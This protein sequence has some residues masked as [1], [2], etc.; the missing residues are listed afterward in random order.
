MTPDADPTQATLH[1]AS[2]TRLPDTTVAEHWRFTADELLGWLERKP[3]Q[4]W[5][6]THDTP[7]W[8]PVLY[9]PPERLRENIK[10]VYALVLD[11]DKGNPDFDTVVDLWRPFAGLVYTTKSH[12]IDANRLRVVMP[13]SRPVTPDEYDRLWQF[14]DRQSRKAGLKT[15]AQA[16]DASRFW[17]VPTPPPGEWRAERLP[18]DTLDVDATLPIAETPALAVVRPVEPLSADA[19]VDRAR[20]YLAKI[21]GAV[22]GNGGHTQTFNAVAHVM[23]GFDLDIDTTRRIITQDYNP[24]CDPPWSEKEIEHKL[25]SVAEKCTRTR[26]YL[27][28]VNR[29]PIQNT[30]HAATR[31]PAA[32]DELD[33]DWRQRIVRGKN[34]PRRGYNNVLAFV[35]HHPD[36]RGRW[37]LN[38]MTG[39]TYFDDR[40]MADTFV[41]DIRAAIDQTL[42]FS[43][44][45]EDVEAAILA[46]ALDRQ[47]HPIQQYLRSVDWDGTERLSN[48]ARD[49]FGSDL[50]IHAEMARKWMISAVARALD[51]GCKVDTALM[52]YGKQGFY[53]SSFFAILGDP[54]HADSPID[55]TNKDSFAQI[56][57]AWIYEFAELENVVHGRANS[58]LKAWLTSTHDMYRAPYARVVERRPRSCVIC[59]TTNQSQF[60][61]DETGS[62]RYWII[63]VA[64]PIDRDELS[65]LRNQLWAE[66]VCA[67]EAGESWW[68]ERDAESEREA[69][70]DEFMDEDPWQ[71]AIEAHL[72]SRAIWQVSVSDLLR[73]VLRVELARQDRWGQ[74]RVARVLKRLGWQRRR[75]GGAKRYV[76]E[77]P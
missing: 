28:D 16:K 3:T 43:P 54:W 34:G 27:L 70:N 39:S 20:A 37:S 59:G 62:R 53:K 22:S 32:P 55:I 29:A 25:R 51:P 69:L 75:V 24:R 2:F 10:H 64:A 4:K 44:G 68:L 58:R 18:G 26:G 71:E 31:A 72:E 19:R 23:I 60:L 6:G 33:V 1:I 76:Y 42:G 8:S 11:Y 48:I 5:R 74:M 12:D 46:S 73:D 36:Y 17:Y 52:L 49:F 13:L 50:P 56:H 61:S 14:A 57:A 30:E 38:T 7:G 67:Y 35:R 9:D 41:H 47:F 65:R 77:R 15:D 21:P 45:R 66:A 63:P 40:P